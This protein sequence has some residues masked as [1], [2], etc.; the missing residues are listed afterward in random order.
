MHELS[1]R[2]I[3]QICRDVRAQE[4]TFSHLADDLADHICCDVERVM[5]SGISFAEAYAL[6]RQ[7]MG[8]GRRLK[9]IQEETLYAVD[10]KYRKMKNTMKVSGIAG[11]ILFGFASLFKIM[12]WPLAGVFMTLGAITL[13][14]LFMPSALV[15]LWKE[16]RSQKRLFLFISAFLAAM[17]FILGI[18][19]KVQHWPG[20]GIIISLAGITAV[21]LLVPS[22]LHSTLASPERKADRPVYI[23]GGIALMFFL[24]GFFFKM[25]HW[26][27]AGLL[28]TAGMFVLCGIA[29]PWY[30]I[31]AY[32]KETFVRAEF[33]YLIVGSIIILVPLALTVIN[34]K[35]RFDDG[36]YTNIASGS[37]QYSYLV[38]T[39][40]NFIREKGDSAKSIRMLE[41]HA[42]TSEVIAVIS[43]VESEMIALTPGSP[44]R[45]EIE[46]A[47]ADY[48]KYISETLPSEVAVLANRAL[49]ASVFLPVAGDEKRAVSLLTALH[50]LSMMKNSVLT[51]ENTLLRT[52]ADSNN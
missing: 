27:F 31:T 18:L 45:M 20:A 52:L 40:D 34:V 17:F 46:K 48:R 11:T 36:Y 47:L 33:I 21:L 16:S 15:V 49:D 50:S 41:L 26:P 5:Q 22:F 9:E 44:Q 7:K 51:V 3:D 37:A 28:I 43:R 12:H 2:D 23:T 8:S 38:G 6:V 32:K 30:V 35:D 42:A 13:A 39:N 29:F 19:F 4:I 10:T 25:M 24:S 1:L 14:F